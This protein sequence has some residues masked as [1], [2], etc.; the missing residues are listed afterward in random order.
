M[1]SGLMPLSKLPSNLNHLFLK[2][3]AWWRLRADFA[4]LVPGLKGSEQLIKLLGLWKNKT[5]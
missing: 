2:R 5:N 3:S 1:Q 4:I